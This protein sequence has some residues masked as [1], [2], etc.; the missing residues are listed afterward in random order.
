MDL[1]HEKLGHMGSRRVLSLLRQKFVWPGMGQDV[2][3]HSRSCPSCQKCSKPRARQVPMVERKILS[4]PFESMAFDLVGPIPKG[5]GGYRYI[6][7]CVC[8]A[9]KWPEAIPIRCMT[10]N[11]VAQGMLDIFSRVGVPLRLL[12]DQGSQFVGKVISKLCENLHIEAIQSTPYHPEGN[13]VVERMHSTL[14]AMLNKAAN[15]GL[16]WVGQVP[17]ALFA[18]RSAP[19]RDSGFSPFEL[20]YGR[21]VR[22]PLDILHQGWAQK[23][24]EQLDTDEWAQ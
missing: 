23:E 3:R 1:A 11:A 15:Q 20:I 17:F 14:G 2:I 6:L 5:K 16:D 8:M 7:T 22:T 18:L 24:F 21:H 12:S 19:N 9:S 10:A 13:G 4:E